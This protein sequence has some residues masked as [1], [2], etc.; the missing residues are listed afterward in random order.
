[1]KKNILILAFL[2]CSGI[3][4]SQISIPPTALVKE[5]FNSI[6]SSAGAALPA[7][8]KMSSAGTGLAS[9]YGTGTNVAVTTQAA[10]SGTPTAG[11]RYN[12]ATATG[13]DRA[14]G[15]MSDA[16]YADD[17]A[18]FADYKNTT[19]AIV[20]S[21]TV[22]FNVE[23]YRI[24]T[25][26]A[27]VALFFSGNGTAWT[28]VPAGDISAAVFAPG[29]SAYSFTSPQTVYKK[30]TITGLTIA[31]NADLYL[32]WVFTTGGTASQGLGLDDVVLFA[33]TA[34]PAVS[35]S[36]R[37][38][39]QVDNNTNG[40]ADAGDQ[41]RYTT[42]VRNTGTGDATGVNFTNLTP[43][44]TTLNPGS[45][46]TSALARD[47][48]YTMPGGP[49]LS[50]A[51]L[52]NDFGLPAPTVI[53]FGSVSDPSV[54]ANGTN[55]AKSDNGGTIVMN[56]NGTFTYT[57][58]A[59]FAGFDR[60]SY[61]AGTGTAPNNAGIVT[62]AVGIVPT[63][64]AAESYNVTGNVS[65]TTPPSGTG[66]LLSNDIGSGLAVAS[67]NG[68]IASVGAAIT[69]T[70]GG[71][72]TVNANGSFTYN[73]APGYTGADNFTYTVDNGFSSPTPPITVSLTVADMVWFIDNNYAGTLTDGRLGSPF[74]SAAA[75]Q[76][77]NDGVGNH[78]AAGDNIF[79]YSSGT[80]YTGFGLLS[81]Q[82]LYG[83]GATPALA[84]LT[85]ITL[86]LYSAAFPATG[87]TAPT[88]TESIGSGVILNNAGTGNTLRGFNLGSS[89]S[90]AL[91]GSNFGTLTV[92]EV[93][94]NSTQQA[95][96]LTNGTVNGNFPLVSS[97]GALGAGVLF[98]NCGG[99]LT[100][101]A[102]TCGSN[103][104]GNFVIT[105]GTINITTSQNFFQA[106]N[107]AMI[108]ITGGHTG[109]VTFQ[110]GTL[111]AI[112][113]TGLQF[114]NADGTYN[115]NGTTTLA[116]GD[117]GI[118][119]LNGSA[120]TFNFGTG[121]AITGPTGTAFNIGGTLNTAAV[122]YSGG[123]T[124]NN[125]G[126]MVSIAN[127][128]AG[129]VIFQTGTLSATTAS[130]GIGIQFDNAD[131]TYNFTGVVTLNGG[132]AGIDILNGS[133]GTINFS[134]TSSA[135]T[136]PSGELIK[137]NA[138]TANFTYSGAFTKN[139]NAT[140]GILVNGET[141]GT[142]TINGNSTK[143]I[144]GTTGNA[145][146]LTS[147]TGTTINFSGNNLLLTTTSGTGFNATGG[148]TVTVAGTGNTI[149]SPTG[150]ALN[151]VS[152]NIGATGLTFQ[153]ISSATGA[154]ANG[155]ILN[156]TGA[157]GLTITGT[158][159]AGSGGTIAGKT[160][161]DGN[162]T[163]GTGIYLSNCSNISLTRMQLN[164]FQNYAISGTNVTNFTLAN[165]VVNGTNGTLQGGIGEGDVYFTGLSGFASI[166]NSTFSGPAYDCFHVFNDAAQTLNR[167][168]ITGCSFAETNTSGNDALAF[169]AT[170]GTFNATVQGC[171]ITS[172]RSDL[173]QLNLLGTV[174]S[175]LIFGGAT[176]PLGNTLTNNNTNI[177]SGGGG[178][179]IGG[180][181]PANNITFT[182]NIS[183]NS[184]KG[185]HGAVL[186]VTKGTG[187]NANFSG[188]ISNNTIGTSGVAGSGSTQGD[189]IAAFLDGAGTYTV[190]ISNN[191][192]FGVIDGMRLLNHNGAAGG[193]MIATIQG[194]TIGTLDQANG[195]GGIYVQT[196][197]AT[198]PGGDNN[199]SCFTIG[200]AGALRN[201]IDVGANA[202]F[203]IVAG[204]IIEQEGVSRV[205]LL[206]SPNYSGGVYSDANVQSYVT[207]NTIY[208][209]N[210]AQAV[211]AF[212]DP[213]SSA[214]GGFFGS[215]PP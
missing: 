26:S 172:A 98:S 133:A 100:I 155:I 58:A 212:H 83:A 161:A 47:D 175:D 38:N 123:I 192:I 115:F 198:G 10:S 51:V 189:G 72:L 204:I 141:G 97:G 49:F 81:N 131:G 126:S 74:K 145:V 92:N 109:T 63:P 197:S 85:G 215:C 27:T 174:S 86:P 205:G 191:Q 64:G 42:V 142:I 173:F 150:T 171:T 160:G 163:Q 60:F 13:T 111:N 182:F 149:T 136:N 106:L 157:G 94:I 184:I 56:T 70:N 119:I 153:S 146:N 35:G 165:T 33:Q 187:T 170:N 124:K 57:P 12:W 39:L 202:S 210:N 1:M 76:T 113:G 16:G 32:R 62:I 11:G 19:G 37:D 105:N 152:T 21:F 178:V 14:I 110:T 143:T 30:A 185:S 44:N 116:G 121:T 48:N 87:G 199:K 114:D 46:K 4:F 84:T 108:S 203:A 154:P 73:P 2:L 166:T 180:G 120:G 134:N 162:T 139:N 65:I 80:T 102:G 52:S 208:T 9:G 179:T 77:I 211:F 129:I 78:P 159:T 168:V 188:T 140:S 29:A 90:A 59:G 41:L 71:T 23:R 177:V 5:S 117:A 130:A 156:T 209:G 158:G 69:T 3:S 132:D 176:G 20:T 164:D 96:S 6:G 22:S 34:V 36:I 104:S 18:I 118:D 31:S 167:I 181:G 68:N 93:S 214:G 89:P 54:V 101:S 112:N 151:V 148:G 125:A 135:I 99:T 207:P 55:N 122:T 138:G 15:F 43:A 82:K 17:N 128:V 107:F 75:F 200:G 79:V 53:S 195:F 88:I 8:W 196:G 25:G 144:A 206:G 127:H 24:N 28:P 137:L 40:Q 95:L 194:N 169:Q 50:G 193:T 45:V 7:A 103:S 147:N 183:N 190:T 66:N 201:S 91:S 67:V 186:A 61:I 213:G